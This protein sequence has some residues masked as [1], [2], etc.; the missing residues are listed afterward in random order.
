MAKQQQATNLDR[1][2]LLYLRRNALYHL[3]EGYLDD[4]IGLEQLNSQYHE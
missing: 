3:E 1:M 2:K 4:L